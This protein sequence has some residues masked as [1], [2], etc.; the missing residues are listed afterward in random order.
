M[1]AWFSPRIELDFDPN[2]GAVRQDSSII[3]KR[4]AV[5]AAIRFVNFLKYCLVKCHRDTIILELAA[6][7]AE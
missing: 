2:L 3:L 1:R 4:M 7:G 5:A 6:A